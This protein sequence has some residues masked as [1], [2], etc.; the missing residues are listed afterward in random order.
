MDNSDQ[1]VRPSIQEDQLVPTANLPSELRKRFHQRL[2]QASLY[3]FFLLPMM[4]FGFLIPFIQAVELVEDFVEAN[5]I[6]R[7]HDTRLTKFAR[8][9]GIYFVIQ[10][11][12]IV[13]VTAFIGAN[14]LALMLSR[15]I[16]ALFPQG[17]PMSLLSAVVFI[18]GIASSF[19][20]A[21]KAMYH[22]AQ[23]WTHLLVEPRF[24]P[25]V[26]KR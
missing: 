14:W 1:V 11:T 18:L 6:D 9:I 24:E 16:F 5:A 2:Y 23:L 3:S 10:S 15:S 17:L 22:T 13:G 8:W 20:L 21:P 26:I 12:V 7:T 19:Y 4:G 25:H